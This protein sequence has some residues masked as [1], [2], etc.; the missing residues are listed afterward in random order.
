METIKLL[1]KIYWGFYLFL[2]GIINPIQIIASKW[3][4]ITSSLPIFVISI[5]I[6]LIAISIIFSIGLSLMFIERNWI[7]IIGISIILLF[8]GKSMINESV[9]GFLFHLTTDWIP[10]YYYFK[11]LNKPL[12]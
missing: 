9:S 3:E 10:L 1:K 2:I 11:K 7:Y 8:L 4:F 12:Q 6:I 5:L